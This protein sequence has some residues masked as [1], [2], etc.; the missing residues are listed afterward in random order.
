MTKFKSTLEQRKI[1]GKQ[2]RETVHEIVGD[3]SSAANVINLLHSIKFS[4]TV[5]FDFMKIEK[6]P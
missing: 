6:T 1:K 2:N 3:L 5:Y 4:V